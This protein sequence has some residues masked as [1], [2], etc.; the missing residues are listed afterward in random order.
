MDNEEFGSLKFLKF[1]YR[2]GGP[3]NSAVLQN[4][5]P[6]EFRSLLVN[7]RKF[8]KNEKSTAESCRMN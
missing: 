1:K 4:W 5:F 8:Q 2:W 3:N 6:Q 7:L